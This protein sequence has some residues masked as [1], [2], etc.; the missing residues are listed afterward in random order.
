MRF[1]SAPG[2]LSDLAAPLESLFSGPL[3]LLSAALV[4]LLAARVLSR[5]I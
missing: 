3:G 5:L 1:V 2:P 4:C